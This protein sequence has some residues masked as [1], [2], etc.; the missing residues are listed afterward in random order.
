MKAQTVTEPAYLRGSFL[1][2]YLFADVLFSQFCSIDEL[3]NIYDKYAEV[4]CICNNQWLNEI[5]D[6]V[7]SDL[8]SLADN[9][10]DFNRLVRLAKQYPEK[11][12]EMESFVLS[13]KASAIQIKSDIL[14]TNDDSSFDAILR[15]LERKANGGDTD[16]ISLF[17]FL[18][19]H[20]GRV[21]YERRAT[22]GSRVLVAANMEETD[23]TIDLSG[24]WRDA[25]T[26][27]RISRSLTVSPETAVVLEKE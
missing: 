25:L 14:L 11:I 5:W 27:K 23:W 22:E 21:A 3:R 8:F 13:Q 16:C 15:I 12:S 4:F 19:H 26:G 6:I 24:S 1:S 17:A 9:A 10:S 2:N 7:S 18:E 20:G